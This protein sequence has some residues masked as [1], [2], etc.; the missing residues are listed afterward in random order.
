MIE[1]EKLLT[2]LIVATSILLIQQGITG[3]Y[4]A[5]FN[6]QTC[7]TSVD[8]PDSC[9]PVYG[10]EYGLCDTSQMCDEIYSATREMSSHQSSLNPIEAKEGYRSTSFKQNYIAIALGLIL[11][12]IVLIVAYQEKKAIPKKRKKKK[13]KKSKSR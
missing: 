6:Q 5:D 13:T 2:I 8:C 3:F 4:L 7:E 1:R 11:A 12:I 9:C 10:E